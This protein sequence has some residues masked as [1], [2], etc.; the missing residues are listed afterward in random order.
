MRSDHSV[1]NSEI[2][3]SVSNLHN[4]ARH[5]VSQDEGNLISS[6]PLNEIATTNTAGVY[7]EKTFTFSQLGTWAVFQSDI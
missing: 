3:Y 1:T 6:V 5:F 4:F 7:F 2:C